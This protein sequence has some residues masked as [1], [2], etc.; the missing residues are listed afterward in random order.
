VR[1]STA[2]IT[3]PG[4]HPIRAIKALLP[5]PLGSML[6]GQVPV[7]A[8]PDEADAL[9]AELLRDGPEAVKII[10]DNLPSDTP[11]MDAPRLTALV[12]AAHA[13]GKRAFVHV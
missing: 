8:H 13:R 1:W 2:T 4:G 12:A 3:V 10:A 6:A 9:V 5:R 7:I 11:K